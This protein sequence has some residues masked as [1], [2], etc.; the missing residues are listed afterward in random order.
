M[1]KKSGR[2]NPST[3][4]I[5]ILFCLFLWLPFLSAC[6]E[7]EENENKV[8]TEL[9]VGDNLPFFSVTMNDGNKVSTDDLLGN[10]SLVVFFHTGCKDCQ[11]ELP[12]LQRFYETYPQYPLICISREE[13]EPSIAA[14]WEEHG[15]TLPYSPQ[16]DR[17]VYQLFAQ[18]IVPR[19]YVAD[20]EGVI[21][22]IYTDNPLAEFEELVDA[23]LEASK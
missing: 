10:V 18:Q 1:K 2:Y 3:M 15:L 9:K 16:S 14:Y 8:G 11:K 4:K 23:V 17:T 21:R 5:K 6:I 22:R 12:V 13:T 20:A 7:D 19:I